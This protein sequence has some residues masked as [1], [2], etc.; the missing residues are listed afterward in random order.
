MA[1][2]VRV[3]TA[4]L[5]SIGH[6]GA[7]TVGAALLGVAALAGAPGVAR[8]QQQ[9]PGQVRVDSV[10]V[11]GYNRVQLDTILARFGVTPGQ[12]VGRLDIQRGAKAVMATG[13][14]DDVQIHA[15]G[16]PG[17]G[18]TLVLDVKERPQ[19]RRVLFQGLKHVDAKD[20]QDSV[21]LKTGE[22]F[23]PV[24]VQAARD[25]IRSKLADEGIP[26]A[27]VQD[28]L[29]PVEGLTNVV[30]VF[31]DVDEGNRVAVADIQ[32]QGNEVLSQDEIVSAMG[33]QPEGFWWFQ[34]GSY[35]QSKY[36]SDLLEKIPDLYHSRGYLDFRILSDTVEV[37]PTTGKARLLLDVD[38]GPQYRIARFDIEG[39][40]VIDDEVLERFFRQEQG[41]L[42]STL[43]IGGGQLRQEEQLGRVYD[44]V[45]F[46]QARQQVEEAYRNEGYLFARVGLTAEKLPPAEP[47]GEH[48]VAVDVQIQEGQPAYFNRINIEGNDYTHEWVIRDQIQILPGDVYSQQRIINS[49]QAIQALGFFETPLPAPDIVPNESTGEVDVTFHVVEKN[50]GSVN[51]G[52]SV[53]G[54]VGLS[55]FIGYDQ[56]NLFG[57]G[58]QGHLRWDFGRYLQNFTVQYQDPALFRTRV[59]GSVSL[60]DAR[61]RF[62][63]FQSGERNRLGVSVRFGFPISGWRFTRFF[64]GYSISRTKYK[65]RSGVDDSSV[66]G[67]PP[68]T[69]SQ[70]S[71]GLTRTTLNHPIFPTQGAR[72]N[73]NL[74]LNGGL[75][76]GDGNFQKLTADGTWRVPVGQVGGSA[77]GS[78]PAVF[79]L[80]LAVRTGF[81]FGDASAFPFDRFWMG[82]VNFGESLRGYDETSITPLGFF[83]ERSSGISD[84]QRLG[85]AFLSLTVDYAFKLND[86]LQL[87]TF[88][89]A[90][91]VWSNP[92]DMDPTRLFRGT[93]IGVQL[94]TPFGPLG[95][96]Y[97]YGFDKTTPGWQFHF[98]MGPGF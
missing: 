84:I 46:E 43:G 89:D 70:V 7:G 11:Q 48:M 94:V 15:L 44:E 81:V 20:V 52:T 22:A 65:L 32:I 96:D 77:P 30:D 90:G 79:S 63:Q 8:A 59:S 2:T 28:R 53:G 97:A 69:Q 26:F 35:E 76:G 23:S 36:D 64:T 25:L 82:G 93:G 75:L 54:G 34:T 19:I 47:D 9:P 10:A 51:F 37:D 57:Q 60:Y 78:A 87:S 5:V 29:E 24:E 42:L 33:T 85:N 45:A 1:V 56:P 98:R 27:T 68:G 39:N 71:F 83:P 21:G 41:G 58:K 73:V 92:G 17:E 16:G 86:S 14:F 62:F 67:L 91:N 88:F 80:G 4:F 38:E 6:R 12:M 72:Q 3:S 13:Q 74:E 49:Y 61:D 50:T 18:A 40:E 55:G 31:V 95:L 66:F